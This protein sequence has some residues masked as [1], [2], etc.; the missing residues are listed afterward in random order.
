MPV[1][2]NMARAGARAAPAVMASEDLRLSWVIRVFRSQNA[3]NPA[4]FSGAGFFCLLVRGLSSGRRANR[5]RYGGGNKY[6]YE[7]EE[8]ERHRPLA[9]QGSGRCYR[10]GVRVDHRIGFPEL[11]C[12]AT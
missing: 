1:A 6:K 10:Q 5:S 7:K 12:G 2:R 8:A 9:R 3:K 4:P 11:Y